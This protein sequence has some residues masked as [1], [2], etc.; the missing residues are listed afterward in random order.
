MSRKGY[1]ETVFEASCPLVFIV[2]TKQLRILVMAVR[3]AYW[4]NYF[5]VMSL[6]V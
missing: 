5:K 4:H 3:V 2:I 1:T 6:K